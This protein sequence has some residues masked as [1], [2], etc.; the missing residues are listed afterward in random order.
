MCFVYLLVFEVLSYFSNKNDS[1]PCNPDQVSGLS[2][3]LDFTPSLVYIL[4]ID[5]PIATIAVPNDLKQSSPTKV[6]ESI[7]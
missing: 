3:V 7:R 2:S 4:L 1:V 6:I 5:L